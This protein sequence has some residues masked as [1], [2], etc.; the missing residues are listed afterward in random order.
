[1]CLCLSSPKLCSSEQAVIL[2]ISKITEPRKIKVEIL[3]DLN[4]NFENI[5]LILIVFCNS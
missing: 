2:N 1:M 5:F 4:L 3:H